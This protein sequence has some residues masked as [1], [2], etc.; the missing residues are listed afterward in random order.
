MPAMAKIDRD[1]NTRIERLRVRWRAS[2]PEGEKAASSYTTISLDG[3]LVDVLAELGI[4]A[5]AQASAILCALGMHS[6]RDGPED[7]SLSRYVQARLV[8]TLGD[9]ARQTLRSDRQAATNVNGL[10]PTPAESIPPL[11]LPEGSGAPPADLPLSALS[12]TTETPQPFQRPSRAETAPVSESPP[13]RTITRH[14]SRPGHWTLK[15]DGGFLG[16]L[17]HD[18][19]AGL[20][21]AYRP[22]Q[23]PAGE[24]PTLRAAESEL[25]RTCARQ[26]LIERR[27]IVAHDFSLAFHEAATPQ[28]KK[29]RDPGTYR[30][31]LDGEEIGTVRQVTSTKAGKTRPTWIAESGAL[32]DVPAQQADTRDRAAERLAEQFTNHNP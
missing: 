26:G 9:I 24:G 8:H 19:D 30:V 3:A 20:W 7:T 18:K 28:L 15:A 27:D 6:T 5:K 10:M 17:F 22:N 4:N 1:V 23:T 32:A 12:D 16:S 29:G 21:R 13:A 14:R 25:L 2:E 31:L 11:S